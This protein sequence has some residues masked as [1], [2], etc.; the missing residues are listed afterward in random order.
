MVVAAGLVTDKLKVCAVEVALIAT[1]LNDNVVG[2]A[3]IAATP[4]CAALTVL[5]TVATLT[6]VAPVL[7]NTT[8]PE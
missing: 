1:L 3:V 8:L 2:V 7:L 6:L 4:V 5:L